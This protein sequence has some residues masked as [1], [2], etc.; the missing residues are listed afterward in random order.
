MVGGALPPIGVDT[1]CRRWGKQLAT[2]GGSNL[3]QLLS[4]YQKENLKKQICW[5]D[6]TRTMTQCMSLHASEQ[7]FPDRDRGSPPPLKMGNFQFT[8]WWKPEKWFWPF[9]PFSRPKATF[10]KYWTLIK[11]KIGLTCAY[12]VYEVKI[13]MVHVQWL[14]PKTNFLVT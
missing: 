14:Q 2:S 13:K 4:T 12:K 7:G 6:C 3:Y 1:W 9:K 11:I 8:W 10:C 5:V